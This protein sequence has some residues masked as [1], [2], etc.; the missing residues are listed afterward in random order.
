MK[1][2]IVNKT[3]YQSE[4][5]IKFPNTVQYV[6]VKISLKISISSCLSQYCFRTGLY[7]YTTLLSIQSVFCLSSAL[8]SGQNRECLYIS[9]AYC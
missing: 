3:N 2:K 5:R 1:M 9:G 7:I 4:R 6:F 8:Y